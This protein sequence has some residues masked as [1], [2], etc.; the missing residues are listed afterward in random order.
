MPGGDAAARHPVQA[1]AGF[2]SGLDPIPDLTR[3]PFSLPDR[4]TRASQLV[5]RRVRS[6]ETTSAGRLFDAVA[7][8]LGFTRA[9]T[10]EGQAA[11]WLEHLSRAAEPCDLASV[12]VVDGELDWRPLLA[13]IIAARARGTDPRPLGRG[14][15]RTLA[16][17]VADAIRMSS[18]AH[19]VDTVVLSG[20]VFQNELLLNDIASALASAPL[21]VWTNRDVPPNDGGISLGQAALVAHACGERG[22]QFARGDGNGERATCRSGPPIA[23]NTLTSDFRRG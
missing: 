9:V 20:G 17:G 21:R 14:F 16:R 10:F 4:F 1:A 13:S 6:F 2:V 18:E 19:G 5:A 3:E 22:R 8:I 23:R 12:N 11:I 7:A 15:H